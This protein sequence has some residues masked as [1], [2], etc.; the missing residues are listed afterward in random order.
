MAI[1]VLGVKALGRDFER[2]A[3][4]A[5][6]TETRRAFRAGAG[7]IRDEARKQA[8]RGRSK[9]GAKQPG[10]LRRAI[11]SFLGRRVRKGEDVISFARVNVLAGRIKAP[12]GH[13]VEFGTSERKPKRGRFMTFRAGGKVIRAKRVRGMRANP[14]FA[15]ALGVAGGRALQM[16]AESLKKQIEGR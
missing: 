11:V 12:H 5:T 6:T 8:P 1:Q 13:L 4:V 3:K 14:F 10:Q 9:D 2:L 15:R 16:V 7:V